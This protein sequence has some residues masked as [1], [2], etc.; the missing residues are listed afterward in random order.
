MLRL[1]ENLRVILEELWRIFEHFDGLL[2]HRTII[3]EVRHFIRTFHDLLEV[4]S[5]ILENR[6][7]NIKTN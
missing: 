7:P 6:T 1:L 2:E 5:R 4:P 3:L